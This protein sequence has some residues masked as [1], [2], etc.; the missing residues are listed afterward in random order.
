MLE[1]RELTWEQQS[2]D[3]DRNVLPA[4]QSRIYR[5]PDTHAPHC[6]QADH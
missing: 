6:Q 3:K 1:K 2:D 5:E 4:D